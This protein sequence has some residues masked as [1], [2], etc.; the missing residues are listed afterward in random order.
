MPSTNGPCGEIASPV[1][2]GADLRPIAVYSPCQ[3]REE[4]YALTQRYVQNYARLRRVLEEI[5]TVNRT[6]L[7]HRLLPAPPLTR[8]PRRRP[9]RRRPKE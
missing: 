4:A 8:P 6:L 7:K 9:R 5:S 2:V 3:S 1:S